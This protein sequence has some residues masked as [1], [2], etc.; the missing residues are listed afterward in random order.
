[1]LSEKAIAMHTRPNV[2]HSPRE[3]T[4]VQTVT[5]AHLGGLSTVA[6]HLLLSLVI[7][8]PRFLWLS[9]PGMTCQEHGVFEDPSKDKK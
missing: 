5:E 9:T 3:C 6:S 4:V 2:C 7:Y 8:H 1:M